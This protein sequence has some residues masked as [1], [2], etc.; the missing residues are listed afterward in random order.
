D[1]VANQDTANDARRQVAQQDSVIS[2]QTSLDQRITFP[3]EQAIGALR[4]LESMRSVST[5]GFSQVVVTF[6]D[7]TDTIGSSS[8]SCARSKGPPKSTVGA[9]TRSSTRCG[10]TLT[11]SSSTGSPSLKLSAPSKKTIA[12]SGAA[13]SAKGLNLF[14]CRDWGEP[15]MS[16]RSRGS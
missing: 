14:S 6:Q 1:V 8:P 15:S 3:I 12:M 10:S 9:A 16:T 7:G 13:T 4:G 2:C 11:C 5:F